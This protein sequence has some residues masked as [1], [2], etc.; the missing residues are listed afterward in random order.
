MKKSPPAASPAPRQPLYRALAQ[1]LLREIDSGRYPVGSALPTEDVLA[2]R[3][4][5]SRHTV[6]Q[7]LREL[8]DEGVI[9]SRAGVGTIVRT[10]PE[11]PRFFSGIRNVG[12]LLQFVE[13][14][15]MRVL[16]RAE[17]V[18]DKALARQLHC[19][20]GQ[21]WVEFRILRSLPGQQQSLNY[22]QAYLRPEL[23]GAIGR[24]KVLRQPIY[25][26]VEAHHG[27]RVVDVLQE[28]TAARLPREMAQALQVGAGA[29]AMRISRFYSDAKGTV[30]EI[31]IGHYPSGRYVQRTR[32]R[33]HGAEEGRA[34]R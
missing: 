21:A 19:E 6:R 33:A 18:A 22:L 1:S 29:A 23:A 14:T 11:T 10:R 7:A 17:V 12:E 30:L 15:E 34:R 31:G 3:S 27:V 32:F 28:I 2:A 26:L 13:T 4:G 24:R 9:W 8:K 20:P 25:S 5:L 16:S